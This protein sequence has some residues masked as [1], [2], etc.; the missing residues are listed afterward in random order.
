MPLLGQFTTVDEAFGYIESFTNLEKNTSTSVRSYR[1]DRMRVLLE[2][3]DH[4]DRSFKSIHIAGTKGKGSTAIFI[5]SVLAEAGEKTGLYTS[6]HVTSY[7]ERITLAGRFF[8]DSLYLD[9]VNTIRARLSKLPSGSLP[10]HGSPTTF[11]LL[12][13]LG[14]LMFREVGCSW[15]VIET[16]I[17]GRLDATNVIMPEACVLTPVEKEHVELLGTTL[18]QIAG[19]KAGIIKQGKPVFCSFQKPEVRDVFTATAALKEAPIRFLADELTALTT[20]LDLE[21]TKMAPTW[22][23]EPSEEYYLSMHGDVQ[24]ENAALAVL[25][26]RSLSRM[27]IP[28]FPRITP[29][30][31]ARGVVRAELPGRME[32]FE[33]PAGPVVLDAAHTPISAMR[34]LDSMRK[35]FP[36]GAVLI[37]GCVQGKDAEGMAAALA[38]AFDEVIISTPGT[39]KKSDPPGVHALFQAKNPRTR[40]ILSPEEAYRAA[41]RLAQQGSKAGAP[42]PILVTGSFYMVS[43]IRKLLTA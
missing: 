19:E 11:E 14:F 33:G 18:P 2:L 17:G 43:E 15:A 21:G 4:P 20:R 16:G 31:I 41:V 27:S 12:T 13:L 29:D 36:Q 8:E 10:A 39:F 3:F 32:F 42:L 23:S 7:K 1:L 38:T 6:P 34:L 30:E 25:T 35:I 9:T 26:L 24:A 37:F 28:G 22:G 5:A 40:L